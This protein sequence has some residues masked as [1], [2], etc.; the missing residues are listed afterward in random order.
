LTALYE[1][2]GRHKG[3]ELRGAIAVA[4]IE[5]RGTLVA[6]TGIT[7]KSTELVEYFYDRR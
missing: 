1:Y 4:L 6:S 7:W 5:S 3:Y 2:T